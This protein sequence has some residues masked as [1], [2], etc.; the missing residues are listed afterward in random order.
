MET[1]EERI[2]SIEGLLDKLY[3]HDV[4]Y[5]LK[6]ILENQLVIMKTLLIKK[7]KIKKYPE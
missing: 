7:E 2:K 1:L 6:E 4:Q 5:L 3:E